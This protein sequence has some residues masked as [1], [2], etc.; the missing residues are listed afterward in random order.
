MVGSTQGGL[1]VLVGDDLAVLA[2][3]LASHLEAGHRSPLQRDAIVV[4][5]PGIGRWLSTR[6]ARRLGAAGQDDG[7]CANVD[8][9]L[10]GELLRRL[11]DQ[12][13]GDSDDWSIGAMTLRGLG[14]LVGRPGDPAQDGALRFPE[15]RANAD[16][17]DQLFRWRPDVVDAW[18]EGR[19]DDPR[20]Q[21][22]RA[23]AANTSSPPPHVALRALVERLGHADHDAGRLPACVHVFGGDALAGGPTSAA[24]LDA[25]CTSREVVVHLMAPSLPRF[26]RLVAAASPWTT[27]PSRRRDDVDHHSPL[28]V[29]SWGTA[30][31][32]TAKLAAALVVRGDL[33]LVPTERDAPRTLLG[34][35]Q[36]SLREVQV[37]PVCVDA[38]V[39]FHA[40]VGALRQVETAR[41]AIL[42]ALADDETLQPEDVGILCGDL[43]RFAPYLSAVFG[44]RGGAPRVPFTLRDRSLSE[45]VPEIAAVDDTLRVLD[46]RFTRSAV[47]DLLRLPSVQRRFGIDVEHLDWIAAWADATGL[48]WGVDGEHRASEGLPA[49]FDAGTW[50]RSLDRLLAGVAM[51]WGVASSVL[52]LRPVDVGHDLDR[53]G[54]LSAA[55]HTVEQLHR[56]T[57]A[58]RTVSQWCD[59]VRDV[60]DRMLES[61]ISGSSWRASLE[62]LLEQLGI[63]ATSTDNGLEF[64]EFRAAFSDRSQ[65]ERDLVVRGSG[66]ATVTSFAPLRNVPFRVLV[67][68]GVDD[69]SLSR[70]APPDAVFGDARVGDRDRRSEVRGALLAAV[71]AARDRLVV[72]YDGSDLVTNDRVADSTVVAEL[73]DALA[74]VCRDDTSTLVR[75]HPRHAHG[76]ADLSTD[77]SAGPFSFDRGALQRALELERAPRGFVSA[78]VRVPPSLVEL[79][80]RIPAG[81]L[82]AFLKAPQRAFLFHGLGVRLPRRNEPPSDEVP[83]SVGE[84]DKW[85]LVKELVERGLAEGAYSSSKEEWAALTAAWAGEPDGPLSGIPGRLRTAE[86]MGDDGISERAKALCDA[87]AGRQGDGIP[88][89]VPIDLELEDGTVLYRDV[90][91]HRGTSVVAWTPSNNDHKIRVEAT[92][93]LLMLTVAHPEV[94]WKAFR[95]CRKPKGLMAPK[96]T[97]GGASPEL[98]ATRARAALELLASL[99]TRGLHQAVPLFFGTSM[100]ML[101]R[102]ERDRQPPDVATLLEEARKAWTPY[103]GGGGDA[104]DTDVRYCFDGN[105]DDLVELKVEPGDPDADPLAGDSRLLTYSFALFDGLLALDRDDDLVELT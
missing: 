28:L 39:A 102:Y 52:A 57:F 58:T 80:R 90:V 16:L 4:P 37:D 68:L 66:G 71:L 43:P 83:T 1:Q 7:I 21:V 73:H 61:P 81:D 95:I 20:G 92:V 62:V 54:S 30:S 47:I 70:A 46:G 2:D 94:Q 103:E 29:R 3:D 72:T 97:V 87:V 76:I 15:A 82:T 100:A 22:L 93:D 34:A 38:T 55:V 6:L 63:D 5:T 86:I 104:N 27:P 53:A 99:R 50:R 12:Q 48:R 40:C 9:L 78:R 77:G 51:P 35:L 45:A 8:F 85:I 75:T 42:H 23:L 64:D 19:T 17:F 13:P 11:Q 31:S 105:F 96:L 98:R 24:L 65:A 36:A 84:L 74:Q 32:D 25:L 88:E 67:L 59:F 101:E 56:S 41:N 69:A 26:E 14:H 10:W 49:A 44:E 89:V 33:R 79:P 91:V 18:L 60:A